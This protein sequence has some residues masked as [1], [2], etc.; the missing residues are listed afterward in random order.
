MKLKT[1]NS[2]G[3]CFLEVKNDLNFKAVFCN[4]GASIFSIVFDDKFMT[5]NAKKISDFKCPNLY[6]GKTIGRTSN[7]INGHKIVVDNLE[8]DLSVNE[9]ENVLHG[10]KEGLSTKI[11]SST[12]NYFADRIEID[13]RYLS[14]HLDSGYP[15]NVDILVRYVVYANEN[16]LEVRY[17]ASSDMDTPLSLT[18]HSYFTLG[19]NDLSSLQLQISSSRFLYVSPENLIA[20]YVAKITPC[21]PEPVNLN[22]SLILFF[23]YFSITL[24]IIF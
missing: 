12:I 20:K 2:C 6:H 3:L 21:P 19:D 22:S 10:G 14:K 1:Y 16:T 8:Y 17:F 7:R 9:G 5:R 18:N 4:L 13:Y 11:F 24:S 23:I 15:G